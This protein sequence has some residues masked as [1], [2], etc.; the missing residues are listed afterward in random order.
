MAET[1]QIQEKVRRLL[2]PL[3]VTLSP[4]TY[5]WHRVELFFLDYNP[6][7]DANWTNTFGY[8]SFD[9]DTTDVEGCIAAGALCLLLGFAGMVMTIWDKVLGTYEF[10]IS[11]RKVGMPDEHGKAL[12]N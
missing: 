3:C 6:Y 11:G 4:R 12:S 9:V 10:T 8:L 7:V 2:T 1:K 5:L